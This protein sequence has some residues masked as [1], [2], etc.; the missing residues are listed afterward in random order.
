MDADRAALAAT[1]SAVDQ[2]RVVD[3]GDV[4]SVV[5]VIGR[6]SVGAVCGDLGGLEVDCRVRKRDAV[7]IQD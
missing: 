1:G 2:G 4:G 3:D 6:V 7:S 5:C